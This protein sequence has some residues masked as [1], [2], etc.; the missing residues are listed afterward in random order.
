MTIKDRERGRSVEQSFEG[1]GKDLS[2]GKG[3]GRQ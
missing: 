3:K 2:T 1:D